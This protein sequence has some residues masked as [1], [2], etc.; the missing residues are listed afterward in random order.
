MPGKTINEIK[1]DSCKIYYETYG[2]VMECY[3]N[4]RDLNIRISGD[5]KYGKLHSKKRDI[6]YLSLL[7]EILNSGFLQNNDIRRTGTVKSFELTIKK[8]GSQLSYGNIFNE[9][10]EHVNSYNILAQTTGKSDAQYY[11]NDEEIGMK[12]VDVTSIYDGF[13][14]FTDLLCSVE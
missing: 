14:E 9:E 11:L 1:D 6:M 7:I 8:N 10:L 2:L 13:I 12:M 3:K 4:N 5:G